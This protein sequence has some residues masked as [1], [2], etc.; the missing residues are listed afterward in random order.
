MKHTLHVT[1]II[2]LLFLTAHFIGL[3]VTDRYIGGTE[4]P[5]GI[6]RPEVNEEVGYVPILVAI[7][8]ATAIA[9]LLIK[10]SA[11]K[12]WKLWFFIAI[13]YSL[14]I[15]FG[16]F[17][18]HYIALFLAIGFALL[19]I[20]RP[21]AILHNFSELFIYGG[22]AG[23]FVPILNLFAIVVLL[24]IVSLYDMIAVWKTKH[25]IKMAKFQAKSKVFAGLMIPYSKNKVAIL[26]G[27]DIGFPL[28]FSGVIMKTSGL[29]SAYIVSFFAGLSLLALLLLSEKK[30][31]YPAMPFLTAGCFI[32]WAISLL[33]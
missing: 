11:L 3:S 12:L 23:I 1:L 8:I 14:L 19:K 30:K 4:L 28:L 18:H 33:I 17:I 25:M 32:G 6:E 13:M 27:G 24:I 5:L 20:L 29:I 26:G 22:L 7:I 31:F 9:L 2:F 10:F 15:S 21:T 16:A